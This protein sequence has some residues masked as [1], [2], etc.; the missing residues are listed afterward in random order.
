MRQNYK[1]IELK[2]FKTIFSQNFLKIRWVRDDACPQA[3]YSL[4][5]K[6]LNA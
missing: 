1:R 2:E 3:I 4:I 6:K 5:N